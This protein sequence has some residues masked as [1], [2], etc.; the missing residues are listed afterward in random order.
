MSKRKRLNSKVILGPDDDYEPI[1]KERRF[2]SSSNASQ[3]FLDKHQDFI[4]DS[5]KAGMGPA[6]IASTLCKNNGIRSSGIHGKQIENWYQHRVKSGKI[7]R[8]KRELVSNKNKNIEADDSDN[9]LSNQ[10]LR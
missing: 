3:S 2:P 9:C 6:E 5:F 8:V 4:V 1:R 10:I 7:P